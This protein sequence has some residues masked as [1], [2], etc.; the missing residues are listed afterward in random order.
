MLHQS[1]L[2]LNTMAPKASI[3]CVQWFGRNY[4]DN[5]TGF[6]EGAGVA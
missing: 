2:S 4:E 1:I 5:S 6:I 3:P